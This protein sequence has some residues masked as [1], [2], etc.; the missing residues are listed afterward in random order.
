M[1]VHASAPP[2]SPLVRLKGSNAARPP[3]TIAGARGGI[4]GARLQSCASPTNKAF[5]ARRLFVRQTKYPS[6]PPTPSP[7]QSQT[8]RSKSIGP[9]RP[10]PGPNTSLA[11]QPCRFHQSRVS[12][13]TTTSRRR[14]GNSWRPLMR[15]KIPTLLRDSIREISW[16]PYFPWEPPPPLMAATHLHM[17]EWIL[18]AGEATL[19]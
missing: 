11:S 19:M 18:S 9:I 14:A 16:E 7:R 1:Y 5:P 12:H 8:P 17:P 4:A 2:P 15:S 10:R 3:T 6:C 13:R